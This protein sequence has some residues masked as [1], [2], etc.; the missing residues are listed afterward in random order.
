MSEAEN[1]EDPFLGRLIADKYRIESLLGGGAMGSVYRARQVA[2]DREVALKVMHPSLAQRPD[3]A[4]RFHRE[5]KASSHLSHPSL[6]A[7]TDFGQEPSGLLYLVMEYV[8]GRTLD[9]VLQHE[10]PLAPA[11]TASIL[12]QVLSAVAVAH[13]VGIVHR[14]LKPDNILVFDG[15]DDDGQ[16]IDVVKVCDFGIAAILGVGDL[17]SEGDRARHHRA[18]KKESKRITIAGTVLGTPAYMSP[19]QGAGLKSDA[20]SDLYA[21]GAVLY[22]MLTKQVPFD[23]TDATGVLAAHVLQE[24]KPPTDVVRSACPHLSAVALHAL[25]KLPDDRYQ[26]AREMRA[27]VR[28]AVTTSAIGLE[29]T[30]LEGIPIAALPSARDRLV[31]EPSASMIWNRSTETLA[32]P[33][34]EIDAPAP[35]PN[36]PVVRRA[37]PRSLDYGLGGIAALTF[38]LAGVFLWHR[39]DALASHGIAAISPSI[40]AANALEP[41]PP[42]PTIESV[43]ARDTPRPADSSERP[44]TLAPEA[45]A[46]AKLVMLKPAPG[47]RIA[48]YHPDHARLYPKVFATSRTNRSAVADMV[49]RAELTRCYQDALRRAGQPIGGRGTAH[50]EIDPSGLVTQVSV[51]LPAPLVSARACLVNRLTSQ[52]IAVAPQAPHANADVL[53]ELEP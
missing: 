52:R 13:E 25:H 8:P 9:H 7:V 41:A 22:E 42:T 24:P 32:A 46:P 26:T 30:P 37:R 33:L 43:T 5:A 31:S 14:D 49:S 36:A 34:E 18:V 20:R 29:G 1:K 48:A 12:S 19:E 38:V 3:F 28:R 45:S 35:P 11:R 17:A 16:P 15:V 39:S 6:V 4:A 2:L 44:T 40:H 51:A 50:L 53:L 10:F 27:A 47:P 23:G 21:L